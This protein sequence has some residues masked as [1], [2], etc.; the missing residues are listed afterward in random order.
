MLIELF[1]FLNLSSDTLT[2]WRAILTMYNRHKY[3][4]TYREGYSISKLYERIC[5]SVR[6]LSCC[7]SCGIVGGGIADTYIPRSFPGDIHQLP[8]VSRL[9]LIVDVCHNMIVVM[10]AK[11]ENWLTDGKI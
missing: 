2:I 6:F 4:Y 5:L 7:S 8:D 1:Q 3:G 10:P 11:V 9:F